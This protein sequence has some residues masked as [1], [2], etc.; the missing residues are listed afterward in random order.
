MAFIIL[1]VTRIVKEVSS[2]GT[3]LLLLKVSTFYFPSIGADIAPK[4]RTDI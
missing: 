4:M 2:V 1:K 3:E